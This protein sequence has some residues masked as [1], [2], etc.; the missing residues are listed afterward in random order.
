[1]MFSKELIFLSLIQ[2]NLETGKKNPKHNAP[3]Q[4][5]HN[6]IATDLI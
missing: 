6:L 5:N 4:P 3:A 1:M 2:V